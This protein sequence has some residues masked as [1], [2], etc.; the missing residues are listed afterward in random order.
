MTNLSLRDV[1]ALLADDL[2]YDGAV[3]D[4][5]DETLAGRAH[6]GIFYCTKQNAVQLL[7][8]MMLHLLDRGRLVIE[9]EILV[10]TFV[11]S[12]MQAKT[13]NFP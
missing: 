2:V 10:L 12:T 4:I 11:T 9:G 7:H 1:H 5:L 3:V 6:Q 13:I 8:V